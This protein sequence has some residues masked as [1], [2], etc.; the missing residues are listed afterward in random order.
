MPIRYDSVLTGALSI[1]LEGILRGRRIEELH[2]EEGSRRVTAVLD[3]DTR[4][5]WMLHPSAGEVLIRKHRSQARRRR[6]RTR[7]VLSR[8]A[9]ITEVTAGPDDRRILIRLSP[10]DAD[11]HAPAPERTGES[12]FLV[13]ELHTNQW[14]ALLVS[15]GVIRAALW[16]RR[17]GDRALYP[18]SEYRGLAGARLWASSEPVADEWYRWWTRS[19]DADRRT[20]LLRDVA[21]VSGLNVDYV[22]GSQQEAGPDPDADA[23]AA[24]SRLLTL[25]SAIQTEASPNR[26]RRAWT[27]IRADSLQPYP[28]HLD[29][30]GTVARASL[31]EAMEAAAERDGVSTEVGSADSTADAGAAEAGVK[32]PG[33]DGLPEDEGALLEAALL[34][35][36]DRARR[37]VLALERQIDQGDAAEEL[38]QAGRLLLMYKSHISRGDREAVVTDLGGE[39]RRIPLDP[40]SNPIENAESYFRRARRREKA[41]RELPARIARE[42]SKLKTL[43]QALA[44]LEESGPT[45][46]LW[47][48]VGGRPAPGDPSRSAGTRESPLPYRR[49]R[50]S[51]GLEIRVGRS[52]RGNDALTFRHSAPDD[53]WLHARQATG[54]HVILRWGRREQ[55]PPESDLR[56]AALTAAQYSEA[57]SSGLVAVDWTRRKYVRKPRKS[58]PGAV[59]PDRAKTVFVEPDP[60]RVRQMREDGPDPS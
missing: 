50:S 18:G 40:A 27:L 17:A 19:A 43:G 13:L 9:R 28:L 56:D 7:G 60:E 39:E 51:G 46:Q 36:S 59:I 16:P 1:E 52:A 49:F 25:R 10:L 29:E 34:R 5:L 48:L 57:R 47:R 58:P 11:P 37:R 26:E 54:A 15:A 3:A 42:R 12:D 38:R 44:E 23:D 41:E 55:N 45:E 20:A 35:Y 24:L 31:L 6:G 53:I 2:F 21:W 30:P 4:L 22:L 14:N 8:A 32:L 33:S